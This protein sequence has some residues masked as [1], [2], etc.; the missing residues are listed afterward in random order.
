MPVARPERPE[1]PLLLLQRYPRTAV[2]DSNADRPV[3]LRQREPH[4]AAVRRPAERVREQ[5]RD[6]L[7]HAVAVG[8][9]DRLRHDR[10]AVVDA[11]PARLLA[12][13]RVRAV[14]EPFHV[15][16]L[17]CERKAMHVELRQVEHVPDEPLQPLPLETDHLER[18]CARVLVLDHALEQCLDVA[19]NRRQRRPQLMRDRHQEVPLERLGF[20]ELRG[21]L[22]E[23]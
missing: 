23:A 7:K 2:V 10:A 4:A 12:E 22:A 6:H 20:L 1:D 18:I 14:D 8:L 13:A 11:A 16:L 15:D 3:D 5:V 21:H 19:A 9:D 17:T